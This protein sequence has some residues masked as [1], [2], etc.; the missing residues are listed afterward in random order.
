LRRVIKWVQYGTQ[1]QP[2]WE[3]ISH[4]SEA[5]KFY[6]VRFESLEFINDILY[7]VQDGLEKKYCTVIPKILVGEVLTLLHNSI[8]GGNLGIKKTLSKIKEKNFWYIMSIDTKHWCVTCD[9]CESRKSPNQRIRAPLQK[10][11]VGAPLERVRLDIGGK[12]FVTSQATIHKYPDAL[13]SRLI[14]GAKQCSKS[15]DGVPT[16]FVDRDPKYFP[17]LMHYLR[18]GPKSVVCHLPTNPATCRSRLFWIVQVSI[19]D[20]QPNVCFLFRPRVLPRR[21]KTT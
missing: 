15:E 6:W 19:S 3:D 1:V 21:I 2:N 20:R 16:Y 8:T 12:A 11:V 5:C 14:R 10:Y 9:I 13:L 17:I 18:D 4:L 7:Y